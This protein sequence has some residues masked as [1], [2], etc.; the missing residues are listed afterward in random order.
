[1]NGV[2]ICKVCGPIV[3][4]FDSANNFDCWIMSMFVLST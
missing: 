3:S 1:M 4:T 2:V